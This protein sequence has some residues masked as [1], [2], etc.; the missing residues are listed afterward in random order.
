M[1]NRTHGDFLPSRNGATLGEPPDPPD[2][3]DL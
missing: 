1:L 2:P 3:P